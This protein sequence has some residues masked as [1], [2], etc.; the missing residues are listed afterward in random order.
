MFTHPIHTHMHPPHNPSNPVSKHTHMPHT[1][2]RKS[3]NWKKV[4]PMWKPLYI[5]DGYQE[6]MPQY[7]TFSVVHLICCISL[8]YWGRKI[9]VSS[10]TLGTVMSPLE[11]SKSFMK[12]LRKIVGLN[13]YKNVFLLST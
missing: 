4:F 7:I 13:S 6:N 9:E 1:P 12:F 11:F 3:I 5:Y 10:E 8:R 2:F